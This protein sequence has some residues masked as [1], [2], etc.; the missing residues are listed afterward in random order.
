MPPLHIGGKDP[1]D[2]SAKALAMVSAGQITMLAAPRQVFPKLCARGYVSQSKDALTV[3]QLAQL[4][5][6]NAL[7]D[8]EGNP[9]QDTSAA[10]GMGLSK[11][12]RWTSQPGLPA[13]TIVA[14]SNIKSGKDYPQKFVDF[15]QFR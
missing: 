9:T 7:V 10:R 8:A 15:L 1:V 2:D 6:A 5:A 4:K 3:Q 13:D 11:S 14:F 12:S